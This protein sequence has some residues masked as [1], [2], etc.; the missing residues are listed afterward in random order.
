[1]SPERA[2]EDAVERD[3]DAVLAEAEEEK[4]EYLELARR[5]QADFEN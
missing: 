2:A 5:T 3:L 1:M 4:E